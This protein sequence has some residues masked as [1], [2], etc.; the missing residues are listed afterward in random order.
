MKPVG[1]DH[2]DQG[3]GEDAADSGGR[4]ELFELAHPAARRSCL[5]HRAQVTCPWRVP[6]IPH[7]VGPR[8]SF[9]R[10]CAEGACNSRTVGNTP[11]ELSASRTVGSLMTSRSE[12]GLCL[13][14]S[15]IA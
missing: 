10:D 11:I 8:P 12:I 4:L 7:K 14:A 3:V 13:T 1:I 9:L 6:L 5:R 2:R 15:S